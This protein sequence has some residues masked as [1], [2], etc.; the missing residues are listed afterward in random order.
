MK[1]RVLHGTAFQSR[2]SQNMFQVP[3]PALDADVNSLLEV[4]NHS[5]ALFMWDGLD[6]VLNCAFQ[7]SDRL[8]AI[9]IDSVLEKTPQMEVKGDGEPS[10]CH[11][12]CWLLC[13]GSV[14]LSMRGSHLNSGALPHLAVAIE[15]LFV[16]VSGQV[17]SRTRNLHAI[18]TE[19][20][21]K[22]PSFL[23]A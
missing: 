22:W 15:L 17:L 3:P 5:F 4:I 1:K 14:F 11:I 18:C 13:H 12:F 10:H 2:F 21:S 20:P 6:L 8:R 19:N 16:P 9:L 7:V 23:L